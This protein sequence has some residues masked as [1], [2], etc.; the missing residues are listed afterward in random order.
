MSDPDRLAGVTQLQRWL[1]VSF[2]VLVLA[3]AVRYVQNHGLDDRAGWVLAGAGLLLTGYASYGRVPWRRTRWWPAVW[4][5]GLVLAWASPRW[6]TP[7]KTVASALALLPVLLVVA[8]VLA[9]P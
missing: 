5:G 6:T 2:A 8:V 4:C 9:S 3:S 1:H 7:Q